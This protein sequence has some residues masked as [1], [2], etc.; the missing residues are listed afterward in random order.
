MIT[1]I[2]TETAREERER[3]RERERDFVSKVVLRD[4]EERLLQMKE[5]VRH[6]WSRT[7]MFG[8]A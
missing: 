7:I 5:Q 1:V 2:D 6:G 3:E 8:C 4:N